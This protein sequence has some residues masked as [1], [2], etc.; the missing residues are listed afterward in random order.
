MMFDGGKVR[1]TSSVELYVINFQP[2]LRCFFHHFEFLSPR[3]HAK[4]NASWIKGKNNS[5]KKAQSGAAP[6]HNLDVN[7]ATSTA[8]VL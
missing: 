7:H 8:I 3:A 1:L 6:R 2:P 4:S 5:I